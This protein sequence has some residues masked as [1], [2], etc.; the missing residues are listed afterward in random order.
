MA[1]EAIRVDDD[2][3]AGAPLSKEE[4]RIIKRQQRKLRK[5]NIV[6]ESQLKGLS[7]F[8]YNYKKKRRIKRRNELVEALLVT[9]GSSW[10]YFLEPLVLPINL[11]DYC[12]F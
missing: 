6:D 7:K 9:W 1:K 12:C 8:I 3:L 10:Y 11:L 4:Q 2:Q 5:F